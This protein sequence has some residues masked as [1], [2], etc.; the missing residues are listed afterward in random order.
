MVIHKTVCDFRESSKTE[1]D[2]R[3]HET[4]SKTDRRLHF[5]V[6]S[7]RCDV[8]TPMAVDAVATSALPWLSTLLQRRHSDVCRRCFDVG[9]PMVVDAVATSAL[10]CLS[11]LLRR[12][13]SDV[14][15]R[16]FYVGASGGCYDASTSR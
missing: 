4:S 9:T 16:R 13:H 2:R 7:P 3:L 11:T 5:D 1:S 8:G 12:R 6:C 14:C 10:R 15:R